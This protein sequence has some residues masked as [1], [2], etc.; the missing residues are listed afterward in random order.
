MSQLLFQLLHTE[1]DVKTQ[2]A[3]SLPE[4][5]APPYLQSTPTLDRPTS[6]PESSVTPSQDVL[7]RHQKK[8]ED[9]KTKSI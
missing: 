5:M 6:L 3:A 2:R 4:V 9:K 8:E 7:N 1:G